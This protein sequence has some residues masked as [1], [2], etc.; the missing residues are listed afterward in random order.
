MRGTKCFAVTLTLA[1]CLASSQAFAIKVTTGPD[2]DFN[3]SVVLQPR[4]Q[5]DWDGILGNPATPTDGPSPNG[6]LNTDFYVRRGRLQASGTA[7]KYFTFLVLLDNPNYGARGN[8]STP[9]TVIQDLVISYQ[10]M[11]YF[12][13]DFGYMLMPLSHGSVASP[14]AQSAIDSPASTMTGRLLNN[15]PRAAREAGVQLRTLLLDNRLLF[16]GGIYEGAR[17][18]SAT[19]GVNP[20]GKPLIGGMVRWNFVGEEWPVFPVGY[21][22]IY[23]DGKSR[24]SIGVGGH[25]QQKGA[26]GGTLSPDLP[27]Y[28]AL[29]ADGFLDFALPG[30]QEVIFQL[31]GYRFDYGTGNARTGFGVATDLGYRIGNIEPQVNAY[32]FNSDNRDTG[33]QVRWAVGVNYFFRAHATKISAEFAS[34]IV[35]GRLSDRASG[36]ATPML[37][38]FIVQSQLSF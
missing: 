7:Y 38:Q 24:A 11:S 36:P 19:D 28:I 2:F 23:I 16:R 33:G 18:T 8:Y 37:H 4:L 3:V 6:H 5:N 12:S 31:N 14:V 29:A 9:S 30:D 22:S 26:V 15:A 27:D 35:S 25:W 34:Q 10:P 17:S 21:P 13:L 32:W 1:V 20:N